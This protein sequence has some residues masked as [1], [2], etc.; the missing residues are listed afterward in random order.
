VTR[1]FK[2]ET[3][4]PQGRPGYQIDHINPLACGGADHP[5]NLQ[6]L[7]KE[8]K[9]AKDRVERKGTGGLSGPRHAG[10][11]QKVRDPDEHPRDG[12]AP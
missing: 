9:Q 8:D 3:G 11:R 12:R 2:K 5:S 4:Y 7:S 6:W 1:E 10:Y